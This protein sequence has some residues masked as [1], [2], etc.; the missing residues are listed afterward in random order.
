VL[1]ICSGI[2]VGGMVLGAIYHPIK[3]IYALDVLLDYLKNTVAEI[4]T[5]YPVADIVL[6][7]DVNL[8][9]DSD[10]SDKTGLVQIV[11]QPTRGQNA[12]DKM[13]VS[14]V[15]LFDKCTV[16]AS[17]VRSD[18]KAVAAHGRSL[19]IIKQN[20]TR[21]VTFRKVTPA[22]HAVFLGSPSSAAFGFSQ[23]GTPQEQYDDF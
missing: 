19:V 14:D 18:H 22:M 6:T 12:L 8:L 17:I 1:W 10:V 20:T 11:H 21:T 4:A 15:K 23:V 3:P 16:V 2:G 7:G 13:H 5:Q 9:R